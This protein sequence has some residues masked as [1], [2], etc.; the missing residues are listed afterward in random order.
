MNLILF[1]NKIIAVIA[2]FVIF[3]SCSG[4]KEIRPLTEHP[5]DS[6]DIKKID[7]LLS[8]KAFSPDSTIIIP[9][10]SSPEAKILPLKSFLSASKDLYMWASSSRIDKDLRLEVKKPDQI[11]VFLEKHINSIVK[12]YGFINRVQYLYNEN[13]YNSNKD[14]I[15]ISSDIQS[16]LDL[17]ITPYLT[18]SLLNDAQKKEKAEL[19]NKLEK[20]LYLLKSERY[21]N[22]IKE[23]LQKDKSD[24]KAFDKINEDIFTEAGF[25]NYL[26]AMQQINT[27]RHD[28]DVQGY[29][30]EMNNVG[31]D[32]INNKFSK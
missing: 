11:S 16:A 25:R 3:L 32:L 19:L 2:L 4:E 8:E 31:K 1:N 20:A 27:Y 24:Q 14:V 18:D 28:P 15:K 12:K 6:M 29:L 17:K 21:I 30:L 5:T 10:S 26:E 9:D 23:S 22:R 7:S 13:Y